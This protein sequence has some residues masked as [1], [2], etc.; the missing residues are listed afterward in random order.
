MVE[1]G[2]VKNING[3]AAT[4]EFAHLQMTAE[5]LVLQLSTGSSIIAG[6]PAA[7]TQ[8]ACWIGDSCNLV[9]G[10]VFSGQ[11]PASDKKNF[12]VNVDG[13]VEVKNNV[14]NLSSLLEGIYDM[15]KTLVMVPAKEPPGTY[16]PNLGTSSAIE[17]KKQ[18]IKQLLK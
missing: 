2:I 6:F 5:C 3:A 7:G 1:I 17:M 15:M 8:V 16:I 9:L 12:T 11:D 18:Q 4:V 14:T 13:L 10:A